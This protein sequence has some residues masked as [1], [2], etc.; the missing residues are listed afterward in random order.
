[1]EIQV[2]TEHSAMDIA[3]Y[4]VDRRYRHGKPVSNLR[5]QE[6]RY[7]LQVI[8][9]SA[10]GKL[11]FADPFE[12]WP[13]GPVVHDVYVRFSDDGGY[14]VKR[15]FDTEMDDSIR[16]FLDAGMDILAEKA[17]WD[18]IRISHAKNSPWDAIYNQKHLHN[19]IIP[20]ELIVRCADKIAEEQE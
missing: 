18:L 19:E 17:P 16:P 15:R 9:G 3:E 4:V 2:G 5:L 6:I 12:A 10:T 20:N 14:P 13:Y 8:H 1:M 7:F 11:L